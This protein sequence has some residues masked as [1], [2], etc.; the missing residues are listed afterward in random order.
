MCFKVCFKTSLWWEKES[1]CLVTSEGWVTWPPLSSF[2]SIPSPCIRHL[3]LQS[4]WHF[5]LTQAEREGGVRPSQYLWYAVWNI[6]LHEIFASSRE[7]MRNEPPIF[8]C[9]EYVSSGGGV[10]RCLSITGMRLWI[11]SVVDWEPKLK[12]SVEAKASP[13]IITASTWAFTIAWAQFKTH[14]K[15]VHTGRLKP[16][17]LRLKHFYRLPTTA[18]GAHPFSPQSV[19]LLR[20]HVMTSNKVQTKVE[21]EPFGF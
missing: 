13:R 9:S 8:R 15:H 17:T 14:R 16:L 11:L 18:A 3:V 1:W 4:T 19:G 10:R 6:S 7:Q 20:V 21:S 12:A 2:A 5:S